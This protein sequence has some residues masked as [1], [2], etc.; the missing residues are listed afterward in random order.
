MGSSQVLSF[1]GIG[2]AKHRCDECLLLGPLF[3]HIYALE[4]VTNSFVGQDLLV[5]HLDR[6]IDGGLSADAVIEAFGFCGLPSLFLG[7]RVCKQGEGGEDDEKGE[8]VR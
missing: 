7:S 4:E 2:A 1:P 5:E 8:Q 6:R 3:L